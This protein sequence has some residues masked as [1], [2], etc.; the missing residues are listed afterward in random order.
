MDWTAFRGHSGHFDID[1]HFCC[2]K[3]GGSVKRYDG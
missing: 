2:Q 1:V 3:N